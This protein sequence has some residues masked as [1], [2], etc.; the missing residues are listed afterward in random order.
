MIY[1]QAKNDLSATEYELY[2]EEGEASYSTLLDYLW[3][4]G[5]SGYEYFNNLMDC[6]DDRPEYRG[7]VRNIVGYLNLPLDTDL[8][9]AIIG[10]RK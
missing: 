6:V 1:D 3:D 9:E 10:E 8:L 5:A 7:L 4:P 2:Y